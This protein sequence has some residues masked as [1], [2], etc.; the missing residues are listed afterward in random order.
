MVRCVLTP[1]QLHNGL[2]LS[3]C[4]LANCSAIM[5]N[6]KTTPKQQHLVIFKTKRCLSAKSDFYCET[7][8][9]SQE[10]SSCWT[11]QAFHMGNLGKETLRPRF[12][13]FLQ[14]KLKSCWSA[15]RHLMNKGLFHIRAE[16]WSGADLPR[17]RLASWWINGIIS[18]L[19]IPASHSDAPTSH[20]VDY[21]LSILEHTNVLST[22]AAIRENK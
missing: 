16:I 2:V 9:V 3:K 12:P 5:P 14:T 21:L 4:I 8:T 13:N 22:S 15:Q 19:V 11:K 10:P 17:S 18:S 7:L 1:I 20:S 6:F